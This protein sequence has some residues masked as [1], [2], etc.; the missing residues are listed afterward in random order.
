MAER[1]SQ[2]ILLLSALVIIFYLFI[3]L[4]SFSVWTILTRHSYGETHVAKERI[5]LLFDNR[6]DVL[7]L[8]TKV[9]EIETLFLQKTSVDLL[10][11]RTS[12]IGMFLK[13]MNQR[14][15][16]GMLLLR[17]SLFIGILIRTT[18]A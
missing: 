16:L 17:I 14:Q 15:V 13:D 6:T 10:S 18:D 3:V 12:H 2:E 5:R 8:M 9:G 1:E 7:D 11:Y 4:L